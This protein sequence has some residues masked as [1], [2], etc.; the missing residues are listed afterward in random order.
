M[1]AVTNDGLVLLER[2]ALQ[3]GHAI[4][5]SP[6]PLDLLTFVDLLEAVKGR[7][8]VKSKILNG[9]SAGR[10]NQQ[11]P[12][13]E[14]Y[15]ACIEKDLLLC[16]PLQH[17]YG[18]GIAEDDRQLLS[19]AG[20]PASGDP[21]PASWYNWN[22]FGD[23][24]QVAGPNVTIK[25]GNDGPWNLRR[26]LPLIIDDGVDMTNCTIHKSSR[27]PKV[28][29]QPYLCTFTKEKVTGQT[30]L[31]VPSDALCL[32]AVILCRDGGYW[33]SNGLNPLDVVCRHIL[34]ESTCLG[35]CLLK[36]QF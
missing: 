36:L 19:V 33:L 8:R 21:G 35:C 16:C 34:F 15:W 28:A 14:L 7:H 4:L 5:L 3:L 27:C 23:I 1:K 29:P 12:L 22:C 11:K 20:L 17:V 18:E 24:G 6:A 26:F 25:C 2:H 13:A 10:S 9:L 32:T 30:T 31:I